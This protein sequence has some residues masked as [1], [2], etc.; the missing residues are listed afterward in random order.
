MSLPD[1]AEAAA[2]STSPLPLPLPHPRDLLRPRLRGW[3]HAVAAPVSLIAGIVLIAVA[4]GYRTPLAVY[5][6]TLVAMFTTSAFYHRGRWSPAGRRVWKRLDHS[7]IFLAIAGGYTAYCAI[8]L[9]PTLA[10]VILVIV[11]T[12]ALAG[13]C[14]Q[15]LWPAAPRWLSAPSYAA[16]GL[17]AVSVL[18]ELL[19]HAGTVALT[20][21]CAGGAVYLLGAAAYATRW[22]NPYP[23][24]FGYHEVFHAC[25][26]I[27][28]TCH[29]IGLWIAINP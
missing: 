28:A 22:P 27:A 7:M 5:A 26:L 23:S 21:L 18:P 29:Y 2:P 15:L 13:V 4:D 24:T 3:L 14:L 10:T 17:V 16:L 25:T 1:M 9:P 11:W 8:A 12:G 20:L 19:D 6:A